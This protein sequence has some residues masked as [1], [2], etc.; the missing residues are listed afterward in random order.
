MEIAL[1]LP[2][3]GVSGKNVEISPITFG[4]D[5]NEALVHQVLVAYL[6]GARSGTR[7]QKTRAQVRGGG[8]KPWKQK[9]TGRARAGTIR[10][11]LWRGGGKV[12]AAE[13]QDHAQ[14]INK[15]MYRGA[16]QSILSELVRQNRLIL[17]EDIQ[18]VRPKTRELLDKL[19]VLGLLEV[20]IVTAEWDANL[21]L[22][23]RNLPKVD[24]RQ[25]PSVDPVSLIK[26]PA[27]VMTLEA[28]RK[29]E[30]VF[31]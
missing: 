24:V 2:D 30:E 8:A 12:F 4:R 26:Y 27:V 14:K 25:A 20:L 17:V 9:G 31:K 21:Y 23:A 19:R 22:S 28:I 7:G 15:K 5:F 29:F 3:G 13:P 11:P 16:M 6:A 18:M 10:S 1:T